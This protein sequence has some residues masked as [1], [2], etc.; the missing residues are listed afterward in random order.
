MEGTIG[1]IR[2]FA[3]PRA[4]VDWM[5]CE[6]QVLDIKNNVALFSVLGAIYGG[7]G[8]ETF[9]LPDLRGRIIIGAGIVPQS[10]VYCV[11]AQI[12]SETNSL[13]LNHL[14]AHSHKAR[15][16]E[17]KGKITGTATAKMKVNN[18]RA[19]FGCPAGHYLGAPPQTSNSIYA[20]QTT[21]DTLANDAISVDTKG[22]TL[23]NMTGS[24]IIGTSG[25][26]EPVGNMQR[27]IALNWIICV[28]GSYPSRH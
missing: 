17:V 11:G 1:E 24:V 20:D 23:E 14:P 21:G 18:E 16:V 8:G 2:C 5:L 7:D 26:G 4:P 12:G 9:A 22:L 10:F 15:V 3:G 6:G 27:T 19:D 28:S 13:D 25:K